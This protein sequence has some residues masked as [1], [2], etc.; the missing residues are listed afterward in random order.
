M[1]IK[2]VLSKLGFKMDEFSICTPFFEATLKQ[3][4]A[5]KIASWML[6]IELSTRVSTQPL[7]DMQGCEHTALESIYKLFDITRNILKEYGRE[8]E[9]FSMLSICM[10]NL[11]LRPFT[12]RWHR[13]F[14]DEVLSDHDKEVFRYELKELQ[15]KL[16]AFTALLLQMSEVSDFSN[17]RI[18]ELDRYLD[19]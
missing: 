19:I 17:I 2:E 6:F 4:D 15:V 14:C 7:H 5:S 3:N 16:L 18:N 8:A 11:C 12:S 13:I 9:S 1:V 10:L